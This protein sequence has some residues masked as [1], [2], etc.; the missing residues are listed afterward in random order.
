LDPHAFTSA[1]QSVEVPLQRS[2]VVSQL[3]AAAR[4]T[5][6]AAASALAGQSAP[7]PVHRSAT[8]HAPAAVRHVVV[9]LANAFVGQLADKPVHASA[10]S[11]TPVASR[12]VA[13]AG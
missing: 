1:G 4:H 12:H 6:F 3:P 5:V 8:S 10:T 7:V 2:T 13:P 9:A 11:Q